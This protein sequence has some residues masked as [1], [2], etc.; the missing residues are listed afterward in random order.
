MVADSACRGYS[1]VSP[2]LDAVAKRAIDLTEA[3]AKVIS[4]SARQGYHRVEEISK[5]HSSIHVQSLPGDGTGLI[6]TQQ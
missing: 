6:G 1:E 2:V 3:G 4:R 5:N